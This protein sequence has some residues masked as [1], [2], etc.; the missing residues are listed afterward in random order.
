MNI[1]VYI[2]M[3]YSSAPEA[4]TRAAMDVWTAVR[5]L[6]VEG[7]T[8]V[9][10]CPHWSHFQDALEGHARPYEEWLDYCLAVVR[11]HD[12]ILRM[13]GESP[14]AEREVTL[15]NDLGMPVFY[16]EE[17][18]REFYDVSVE[19]ELLRLIEKENADNGK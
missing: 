14:G 5:D 16:D 3:P 1:Y 12:C 13:P 6:R 7:V 18:L 15:A 19:K 4:N 2:A 17:E 9:P 11:K 10:T 8:F